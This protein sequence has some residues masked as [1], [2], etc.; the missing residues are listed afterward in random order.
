MNNGHT[1][2]TPDPDFLAPRPCFREP[3]PEIFH[4]AELLD[5]A[6]DAHL[7]GAHG[8]AERLIAEAN[9]PE[10]RNWVESLWGSKS[11]QIHRFRS[12]EGAPPLLDE[13][14]RDPKRDANDDPKLQQAIISRDGYQCRFCGI[15]VIHSKIRE[16]MHSHY[17]NALPWPRTNAGQ[18]TAFQCLWLQ[19]DH[20]LPHCRGGRTDI[21]NLVITCGPCNYGRLAW[22]LEEV[23]L[24]DP[25]TRP[26]RRTDWDGLERFV[27][28]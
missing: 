28:H 5:S 23:G 12:V 20:V 13:N 1:S 19:F 11:D 21:E 4:A 14:D 8:M 7:E 15:P 27:G 25:R 3:V 17:G 9:M 18:H 16:A 26:V 22:T 2:S 10:V 24:I 6:V